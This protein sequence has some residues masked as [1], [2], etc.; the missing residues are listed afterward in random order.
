MVRHA[1]AMFA[2]AVLVATAA[3]EPDPGPQAWPERIANVSAA[4]FWRQVEEGGLLPKQKYE[5]FFR[6][7]PDDAGRDPPD[8]AG[9]LAALE[10]AL[11]AGDLRDG[12]HVEMLD[13]DDRAADWHATERARLVRA[14]LTPAFVEG[15]IAAVARVNG[16]TLITDNIKDFSNFAELRVESWLAPQRRPS[17]R[18]RRA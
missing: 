5:S 15:Q 6:S 12:P 1:A 17:A 9:V 2:C 8:R 18:R 4:E 14:G 10:A 11:A 16:L 3:A 7:L 13:Y